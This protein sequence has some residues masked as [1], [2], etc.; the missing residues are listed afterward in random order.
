MRR[1]WSSRI[2]RGFL[3]I[4]KLNST[5]VSCARDCF[6]T[7]AAKRH[8]IVVVHRKRHGF[9]SGC[10]CSAVL[11]GILITLE[12]PKTDKHT[13]RKKTENTFSITMT[14]VGAWTTC[15]FMFGRLIVGP[16]ATRVGYELKTV[17]VSNKRRLKYGFVRVLV[18][19]ELGRAFEGYGIIVTLVVVKQWR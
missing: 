13:R 10:T 14:W 2:A 3:R 8:R 15:A 9:S 19:L 5:H 4:K 1:W 6:S 18:R 17:Y 12:V 16:T 7:V 11:L